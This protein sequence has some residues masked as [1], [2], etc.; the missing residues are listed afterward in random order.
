MPVFPNAIPFNRL[1]L[2]TAMTLSA[3]LSLAAEV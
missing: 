1:I 2:A 3:S